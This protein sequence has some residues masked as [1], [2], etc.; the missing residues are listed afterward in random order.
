MIV[1][2]NAI[3]VPGVRISKVYTYTPVIS[4]CMCFHFVIINI[5]DIN[6][7]YKS[8]K[9]KNFFLS[10]WFLAVGHGQE[11]AVHGQGIKVK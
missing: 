8:K 5:T 11:T 3:W 2:I 7:K 9:N 6:E 10:F 4:M 1:T